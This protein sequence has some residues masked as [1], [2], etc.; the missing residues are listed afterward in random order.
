MAVNFSLETTEA[1]GSARQF[2]SIERNQ[3]L[4]AH[5][6]SRERILQEQRRNK[7]ILRWEKFKRICC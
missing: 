3:M 4:A 5:T 7:N 1:K 2:S 6:T